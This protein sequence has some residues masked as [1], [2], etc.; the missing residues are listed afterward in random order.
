MYWYRTL[1]IVFVV[2]ALTTGSRFCAAANAA[3]VQHEEQRWYTSGEGSVLVCPSVSYLQN[4]T[5][6]SVCTKLVVTGQCAG[7]NEP[8]TS[9]SSIVIHAHSG[10]V[11]QGEISE[12]TENPVVPFDLK[13][14]KTARWEHDTYGGC[15][16]G[17]ITTGE[18][19]CTEY[20][21]ANVCTACKAEY[22]LVQVCSSVPSWTSSAPSS[23]RWQDSTSQTSNCHD[24]CQSIG[25]Q[26]RKVIVGTLL[27]TPTP[28]LLP[29]VVPSVSP[30]A[31]ISSSPSATTSTSATSTVS[32]TVIPSP[33][34][35]SS[36]SPTMSTSA[37]STVSVTVIPSPSATSSVSP[38]MSTSATSTVSVTVIPSPSATSSVSP[39]MSTSATSAM[40]VTVIP[41]PSATSSVSPTMST[42]ATSTV[43][44][45]VF[46][47]LF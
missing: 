19:S 13:E 16:G 43:S 40:S 47:T 35:T 45:V 25:S 15:N 10:H 9:R 5:L 24:A 30:S 28:S 37:T 4:C 32:V 6:Q 39:T 34:A 23:N 11:E 44:V 31:I 8:C 29:T 12:E 27:P 2:V 20:R 21:V 14:L 41:S 36:V 26:C 17:C 7:G 22:Q 3:S 18:Y 1:I 38:T 46:S 33:S 42:S